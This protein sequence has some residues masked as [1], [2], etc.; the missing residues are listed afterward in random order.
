ME[1]DQR[2]LAVNFLINLVFPKICVNCKSP[3]SH[4]CS[5]C[6]GKIRMEPQNLKIEAIDDAWSLYDYSGQ[7]MQSLIKSLKY[8]F[9]YELEADIA[10]LFLGD[11]CKSLITDICQNSVIVPIPLHSRR[12]L[13]RG[14]N[15]A[16]L[17][18]MA[19]SGICGAKI[20]NK[21]ILRSR[22]SKQQARNNFLERKTNVSEIFKVLRPIDNI[23]L[24]DD[25]VTTGSTLSEAAKTLRRAGVKKIKALTLAS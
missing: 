14:F 24:I 16:Q 22:F 4:L 13:W 15:Q 17:I 5:N 23:V 19:V 20:D 6:F 11:D 3:G 1:G 7:P 10:K 9:I 8:D 2:F 21:V 18:A 25:V 12:E